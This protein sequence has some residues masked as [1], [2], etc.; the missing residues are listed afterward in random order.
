ML[1]VRIII[2]A[3]SSLWAVASINDLDASQILEK[4]GHDKKFVRGN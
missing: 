1:R 3:I 2:A 4:I